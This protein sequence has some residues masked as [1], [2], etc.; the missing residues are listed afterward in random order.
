R[1]ASLMI[2]HRVATEKG[3]Q[4]TGVPSYRGRVFDE[5]EGSAIPGIIIV[6][7][8]IFLVIVTKG[9][10]LEVLLWMFILG[11]RGGGGSCGG[12]SGRG[13]SSGGFGGFG[14]FGGGRSGGGGAGGGF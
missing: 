13:G 7:I 10:I 11:G 6:V 4:L 3:V 14:G 1:Q 8:F 5:G 9:R 2:L 12:G